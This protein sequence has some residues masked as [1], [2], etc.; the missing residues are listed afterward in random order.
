MNRL[1]LR[2]IIIDRRHKRSNAWPFFATEAHSFDRRLET[3]IVLNGHSLWLID[4]PRPISAKLKALF[5]YQKYILHSVMLRTKFPNSFNISGEPI[6]SAIALHRMNSCRMISKLLGAKLKNIYGS[7]EM[8]WKNWQ[9]NSCQNIAFEY[10]IKV[11][12]MR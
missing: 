4:I 2:L 12:K 1:L 3:S 7:L 5:L 6:M 8:L 11:I 9:F 10:Y